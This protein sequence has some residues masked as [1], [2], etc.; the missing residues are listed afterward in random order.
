MS[1]S[2]TE[3]HAEVVCPFCCL[4]CDDLEVA[5]EGG[6]LRVTAR[7]CP[8]A[9]AA[10]ARPAPAAPPQVDGRPAD[11][12][13]AVARAAAILGAARLPVLAG[14]GTDTA[15]MRAAIRLAE[16]VGGVLDHA[17]SAGL[18]ANLAAMRTGGWVT[19]TLA[20][21]RNRADLVLLVGGDAATVAPRLLERVLRPPRT[22]DGEG[23]PVRRIVQLG[24]EPSAWP[25][26]E[27]VA[28]PSGGLLAA[29]GVLRALVAGRRLPPDADPDGALA[30]LATALGA[31]RYAA[32]AWAA[33]TLPEAEPLVA[34]LAELTKSL[35]AKGRAV[36]LPLAGGDNVIG[37]SQVAAWQ[38]GVPLPLGLAGGVPDHDP[39]RWSAAALLARGAADALLWVSAFSDLEPPP[40]AVPTVVLARAG[41]VPARPVEV[42]IP[43]GVPGLDHAGSLY[44]TDGVVVLPV[45]RLRDTGLPGVAEVLGAIAAALEAQPCS[46]TRSAGA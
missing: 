40:A 35:N 32:I 37:A 17:G 11:M 26:I 43:V 2:T 39:P 25:G 28:C 9:V 24:G 30:G 38:T 6:A 3:S 8:R 20:E 46:R 22:L 36:G 16:R 44:R 21:I 15:G 34:H 19:G 33:G 10:F 42:L 5:A 27:H 18:L 7:G 13:A 14:L 41:F 4:L 23:P 29:V 45:R 31:A 12:E 1:M